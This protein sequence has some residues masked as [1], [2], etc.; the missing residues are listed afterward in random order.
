MN[1]LACT[2]KLKPLFLPILAC[3]SESDLKHV[4]WPSWWFWQWHVHFD[5]YWQIIPCHVFP[6]PLL[7]LAG[8]YNT[9]AFGLF[10][11]VWILT[12][13]SHSKVNPCS[14][15][16]LILT[17]DLMISFFWPFWGHLTVLEGLVSLIV[18]LFT[19]SSHWCSEALLSWKTIEITFKGLLKTSCCHDGG[20]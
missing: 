3:L 15:W 9:F 10:S 7:I 1:P 11:I 5:K 2:D 18:I 8:A 17:L 16:F 12:T 6:W 4:F 19:F 14:T 13:F 20:P